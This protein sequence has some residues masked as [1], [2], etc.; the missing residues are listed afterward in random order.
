MLHP[1]ALS[2]MEEQHL[3]GWT[4]HSTVTMRQ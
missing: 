4:R 3:H 1:K 2:G